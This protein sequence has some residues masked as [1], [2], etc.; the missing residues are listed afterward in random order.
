MSH[1]KNI[2]KGILAVLISVFMLITPVTATDTP[3][4]NQTVNVIIPECIGINVN[5]A[6]IYPTF[7]SKGSELGFYQSEAFSVTN[8]GNVNV[9]IGVKVNANLTS[10]ATQINCDEYLV[11]NW[12]N[13]Y[14]LTDV[15][16]IFQTGLNPGSTITPCLSIQRV[17]NIT[18]PGTYT[19]ILTYTAMKS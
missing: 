19:S 10:G 3:I 8:T 16:N 18:P 13:W 9:D 2:F 1:P 5:P 17:P 14:L 6:T 7:Q 12:K 11:V 15:N 4:V